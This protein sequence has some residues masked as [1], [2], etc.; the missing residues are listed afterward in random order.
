MYIA[1]HVFIYKSSQPHFDIGRFLASLA[2]LAIGF[3]RQPNLHT[4]KP[5]TTID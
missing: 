5:C 2:V 3:P 1:I 4:S